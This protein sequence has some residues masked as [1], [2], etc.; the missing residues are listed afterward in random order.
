M[1]VRQVKVHGR[2]VWQARVAFQ[3]LRSSRV[4][5][6]RDAAKL[7]QAELLQELKRRADQAEQAGLAPATLRQLFDA[8]AEDLEARAKG[9]DT[10]AHAVQ[11]CAVLE[12]LLPELL[13]KPVSR[14]TEADIF[15]FRRARAE[16]SCFAPRPKDPDWKPARPPAPA[17][18]ATINRDLRTLRAMLKRVLPDF[19]FPGGAFFAEDETAGP[20]AQARG[21]AARP[22][23]DGG[24]L[25]H[26]REARRTDADAPL[27]DPPPPARDG[28]PRAGRDPTAAGEGRGPVRDA[29]WP[30]AEAPPRPA[31]GA[32]G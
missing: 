5:P 11:T 7:A 6:S 27:G 28:A 20:L 23:D 19:R 24:A 12:A 25:S 2:K 26:H 9:E 30:G 16:R 17:K 21:G 29:Q 14:I 1:S 13:A 3:G 4:C 18:P 10:I 15:T 22:R 8:Y 31:R 32:Q